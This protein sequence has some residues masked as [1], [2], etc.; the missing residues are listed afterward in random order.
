[1]EDEM[2]I[3]RKLLRNGVMAV[4]ILAVLGFVGA[5][6]AQTSTTDQPA[7]PDAMQSTPAKAPKAHHHAKRHHT[8][9]MKHK[10]SMSGKSKSDMKPTGAGEKSGY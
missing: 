5:S 3:I 8:G 6:L 4:S 10:A 7:S 9:H 2:Q 1:M